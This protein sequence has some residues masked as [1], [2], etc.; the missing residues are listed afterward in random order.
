MKKIVICTTV[1]ITLDKLLK[2]QPKYLSSKYDVC[3]VSSDK[4]LLAKVAS[5]EGVN[6]KYINMHRDISL[7]SDVIS[8]IKLT[9]FFINYK[10]DIVHSYTPKAGL[11][12]ALAGFITRVPVRIHTF[13]GLIFPSLNGI[14]H[15]IVKS[16]DKLICKMNTHLIPEGIG[17]RS[18]LISS[19]VVTS[20]RICFPIGNGNINGIDVNYFDRSC[21]SH[22]QLLDFNDKCGIP[23]SGMKFVFLGR[24]HKDKG[25]HELISAFEL[26]QAENDDVQLIIAGW[27]ELDEYSNIREIIHC[28]KSIFYIGAID[29]VRLLLMDADALV[30]PS[31]REGFPNV[32]MQAGAMGVPVI[33]SN[34]T[35]C[36]E[37]IID[38]VN[39][40]LCEAHDAVSLFSKLS[41]LVNTPGL[42][43]R[44]SNASRGLISERYEQNRFWCLLVKF[45]DEVQD[46]KNL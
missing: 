34:I 35:G 26:L 3:I 28:S 5:R 12:C 33:A 6:Y 41:L 46:E 7:L 2:G 42:R 39:G 10:P 15:H 29:D 20:E 43:S 21:I 44:L 9:I 32:L 27:D 25:I 17:V 31:Y 19:G 30:L 4:D 23:S 1:A 18:Q 40:L 38:H 13:T 11:L 16:M 14:K 37:I 24:L 22:S 36:N 8:L 45:Y